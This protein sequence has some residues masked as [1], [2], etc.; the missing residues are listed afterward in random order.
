M[1][2]KTILGHSHVPAF[3]SAGFYMTGNSNF[4]NVAYNQ[5]G[6]NDDA[7]CQFCV[8]KFYGFMGEKQEDCFNCQGTGRDPIPMAEVQSGHRKVELK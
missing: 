2:A 1:S 4:L 8:G 6:P 7:R 3:S 5:D